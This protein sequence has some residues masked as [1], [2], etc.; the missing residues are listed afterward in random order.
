LGEPPLPSI[1]NQVT[2]QTGR[3]ISRF[4]TGIT[5][6]LRGSLSL[7]AAETMKVPAPHNEKQRKTIAIFVIKLTD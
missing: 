7:C 6:I 5:F 1:P 3:A 2:T 4:L